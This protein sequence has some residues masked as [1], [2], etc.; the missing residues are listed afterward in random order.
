MGLPETGSLRAGVRT[1]RKGNRVQRL[2]IRMR[3]ER[4][5]GLSNRE[6]VCTVYRTKGMFG[7][8]TEKVRTAGHFSAEDLTSFAFI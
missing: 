8:T 2:I 4:F 1:I 3:T 7:L 5:V 6:I